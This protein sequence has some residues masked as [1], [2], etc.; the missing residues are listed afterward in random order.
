M[1]TLKIKP[2]DQV[3]LKDHITGKY[4]DRLDAMFFSG[5]TVSIE[6]TRVRWYMSRVSHNNTWDITASYYISVRDRSGCSTELPISAISRNYCLRR[7][8]KRI[9]LHHKTLICENNG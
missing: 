5:K 3:T 4:V 9:S 1:L 7:D 8:H 6:A 2:N